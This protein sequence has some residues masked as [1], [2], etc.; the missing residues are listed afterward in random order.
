MF[1][2]TFCN[3]FNRH[4]PIKRSTF[5]LM[6]LPSYQRASESHHKEIKSKEIFLKNRT[7]ISNKN[8]APKEI[9]VQLLKNTKKPNFEN[10]ETKKIRI[11][12]V[13]VRLSYHYLSK[14]HQN[15]KK[16]TLL[17]MVKPYQVMRSSVR[18]LINF[19]DVVPSV[20]IPKI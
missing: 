4:V 14:F 3:I 7:D 16:L 11:K 13:S 1:K 17:M 18:Y 19:S 12:V 8:T 15:V 2:R 6:K 9:F 20:N 5:V 10:L